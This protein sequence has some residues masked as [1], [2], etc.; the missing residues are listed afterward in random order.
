MHS[1]DPAKDDIQFQ[2]EI[3][4]IIVMSTTTTGLADFTR[5]IFPTAQY[6]VRA[7]PAYCAF[8]NAAFLKEANFYGASFEHGA[9]FQSARFEATATFTRAKF[10][11]ET[12]FHSAIFKGEA[13]FSTDFSH[14]V[15]FVMAQFVQK[16]SFYNASFA[17]KATF[18]SV[19]F[20]GDAVFARTVFHQ[21]GDFGN[22]DFFKQAFFAYAAFEQKADFAARFM[23]EAHFVGTRF[24]KEVNFSEAVFHAA[25]EFRGT[26]FRHDDDLLPG[27]I[28][29]LAQFMIP[30]AAV[31]YRTYLGQALFYNC[32]VSRLTFSS[33]DW[34][35]RRN[36]KRQLFEEC[37][38][39][40][41]SYDLWDDIDERDYSL[42][43]E[44]Y[45]QL[46]KNYDNRMDYWTAGDFHYGE[47]EMKRLHSPRKN[48]IA[49]WAH[50]HLGLVAWYRYASEYGES[51]VRPL[52]ALLI[53]LAVFTFL[54][55]AAGLV[56]TKPDNAGS[57][58]SQFSPLSYSNFPAFI[59]ASSS[60]PWIATLA[61]FGHS[62]MTALSVA[63]FQKELIYQ[64][65]YP[66]GRALALLELLLT[67]TLIALFLLALRR[68]FR[69]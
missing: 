24:L 1:L 59:H 55:P 53:V 44:T 39:L 19:K 29:S 51:Y 48:K 16:A 15:S 36:G 63:G 38:G 21:D 31:F 52:L 6:M 34:R 20:E 45:Q 13:H 67:S 47:M 69:R 64:P 17:E 54:F 22:V 12:N 46:K 60:R 49:R 66:W 58:Q 43:A 56:F 7:F 68:Q 27:P 61:F 2:K 32:D 3:D 9:D 11:S 5:F 26:E 42:I 65:A 37:V 35:M 33:V 50:R 23:G 4:L 57:M 28:F 62:L 18:G 25:V 41:D 30:E 14:K 40:G 8:T 10:G